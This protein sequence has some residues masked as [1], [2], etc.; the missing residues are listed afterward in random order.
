MHKKGMKGEGPGM[1]MPCPMEQGMMGQGKGMMGPGMHMMGKCMMCPEK[2]M[3]GPG[4]NV[5]VEKLK[6]GV[7]ITY[8]SSD[9]KTARRLQIMA[10][11]MKLRREMME[12]QS[13]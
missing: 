8:S 6:D 10:E 4:V 5:E 9:E 2:G 1:G 11:M 12:L 3:M 7:A 13:R